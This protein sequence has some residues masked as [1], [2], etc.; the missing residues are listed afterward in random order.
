MD[1]ASCPIVA[2]A[3]NVLKAAF[4]KEIDFFAQRGITYL[5]PALTM[6]EPFLLRRQMFEAFRDALDITEDESDF[7]CDEAWAAMRKCDDEMQAKGRPSSTRSRPRGRVAVLLIGRPYHLDPGLNHSILEEFQILGYPVLSIR[8]IPKD[9][10]YLGKY[11]AEDLK[12]GIIN[13]PLEI[14]DVWPENYSSNSAMKV[15]AA[16]F[17]AHHRTW[18]CSICRRSSA[19]TTRTHLRDHRQHHRA[20]GHAVLGAATT[21]S[22]TSRAARSRSGVKTYAHSLGLTRSGSRTRRKEKS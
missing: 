5:D 9:E 8:S 2:G 12:K 17:A 15:W 10:E 1:Y 14:S 13:S 20:A 18:W 11:F 7:A 21:S 3:P 6:T 16:K 22:P 19:A 4:T